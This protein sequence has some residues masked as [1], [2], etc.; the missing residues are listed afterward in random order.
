MTGTEVAQRKALQ[1]QKWLKDESGIFHIQGKP[2]SGK[3]TLMKCIWQRQ[4]THLKLK[5][6]A[7][8]RPL[9]LASFFFWKPGTELQK[10]LR[11]LLRGLLYSLL[12]SARE[13]ISD[14]LPSQWNAAEYDHHV[15]V[16]PD[17]IRQALE[18]CVSSSASKGG[19]GIFFAIDGLDEFTG[20]H[21][22]LLQLL[23]DW[24]SRSPRVKIL[25][26]SREWPV[27]Q[28]YLA[29]FPR[30]VLQ[31]VTQPDIRAFIRSR[32]QEPEFSELLGEVELLHDTLI[33]HMEQ[34]AEGV[35][36]WVALVLRSIENGLVD[37]DSR[38]DVMRTL[39]SMP[40][41]LNDLYQQLLDSIP[42][43]H[44]RCAYHL[45]A[46]TIKAAQ[47]RDTLHSV[48]RCYYL[49]RHMNPGADTEMKKF[50]Q[51]DYSRARRRIYGLC[52]G[53]LEVV[54]FPQRL[55]GPTLGDGGRHPRGAID[56]S[57]SHIHYFF[58]G[59]GWER[60]FLG[61]QVKAIHRTVTEY[62][63]TDETRRTMLSE[64]SATIH[65]QLSSAT[66]VSQIQDFCSQPVEVTA[67]NQHRF[68]AWLH[69][70][71]FW[72]A[73]G[74]LAKDFLSTPR[75]S[76]TT[77]SPFEIAF[78]KI[79][80][81]MTSPEVLLKT[82]NRKVCMSSDLDE[83][84]SYLN[85]TQ[86]SK[87][88]IQA[89]LPTSMLLRWGPPTS[90]HFFDRHAPHIHTWQVV[91]RLRCALEQL[92]HAKSID[93]DFCA[94]LTNCDS[95]L[96]SSKSPNEACEAKTNSSGKANHGGVSQWHRFL[97]FLLLWQQ[98]QFRRY[99]L[100]AV[101]LFLYHGASP[102]ISVSGEC[103]PGALVY[104]CRPTFDASC[105]DVGVKIHRSYGFGASDPFF[106]QLEES[107]RQSFSSFLADMYP[108]QAQMLQ[109]VVDW[110]LLLS[111]E[112]GLELSASK[113][114]ELQARF[115]P[116]LRPLFEPYLW[117]NISP[118]NGELGDPNY[119]KWVSR[120][121]PA[122]VCL[123]KAEKGRETYLT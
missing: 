86:L 53:F 36:L 18:E 1:F 26:S 102:R 60:D 57:F 21:A 82:P 112:T 97:I 103:M 122:F 11:G 62:L 48:S 5:E 40:T 27:F 55:H 118:E 59:T 99:G 47:S 15:R 73:K 39:G 50:T 38:E 37:G 41:E 111:N 104:Y 70:E 114:A 88:D 96:K 56:C 23:R 7:G 28:L 20:D 107:S 100:A 19:P 108:E 72:L 29:K 14:L 120:N 4:I 24:T 58:V 12:S 51:E 52:K 90:A 30:I 71:L 68:G 94:A 84:T 76:T 113:K 35:F 121:P 16:E 44:Q 105:P 34:K 78:E 101:A 65:G 9:Y 3:S 116:R 83:F 115:G 93:L 79:S 17:D 25:V 69:E 123:G 43:T 61:G 8:Q 81:A 80:T 33:D 13:L 85:G 31:E 74:S 106:K 63:T 117:D 32:L 75:F 64:S 42:A 49:E 45:L 22:K 77:M 10:N 91:E 95:W 98:G 66:I 2:G 46:A 87:R 110:V 92:R 89:D 54:P 6:W 109:E 119:H 67:N